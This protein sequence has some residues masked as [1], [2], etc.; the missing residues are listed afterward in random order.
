[1]SIRVYNQTLLLCFSPT[2]MLKLSHHNCTMEKEVAMWTLQATII[3]DRWIHPIPM[4]YDQNGGPLIPCKRYIVPLNQNGKE[5][6]D[7]LVG[8]NAHV[9]VTRNRRANL[10]GREIMP[11][12][13]EIMK[14]Y[15]HNRLCDLDHERM[16]NRC[17]P[18][19]L[20]SPAVTDQ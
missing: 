6:S 19:T 13:R 14:K 8:R 4:N 20:Q 1:M 16:Q 5:S 18:T 9:S 3:K 12:S 17:S 11:R 7:V 15:A 10:P 2:S